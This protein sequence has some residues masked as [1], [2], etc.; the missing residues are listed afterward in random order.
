MILQVKKG[1]TLKDYSHTLLKARVVRLKAANNAA[2][3][4]KKHKKKQIQEGRTLSQAEAEEIVRQRD[5]KAKVE[6]ER[7]QVG[8]SSKGVYYCNIY[9]KAGYNKCMC[10]KDTVEVDN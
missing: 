7:V 5:T 3:K 9:S 2:S 8:S 1:L 6:V 10:K 4:R